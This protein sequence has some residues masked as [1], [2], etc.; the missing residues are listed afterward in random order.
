MIFNSNA[1]IEPPPSKVPL[2]TELQVLRLSDESQKMTME[3][4]RSIHGEDFKLDDPSK[5]KDRGTRMKK[6]Y[7]ED[8]GTLIVQSVSNFSRPAGSNSNSSGPEDRLRR[9]AL[10]K[11]ENYGFPE[12]HCIEAYDFCEGDTDAALLLLFRKYMRIPDNAEPNENYP[13]DMAE[14]ELLELRADEKSALES[15]YDTAFVEKEHNHIWNLKFKIDHLLKHSPSETR[16]QREAAETASK[17]KVSHSLANGKKEKSR[18]RN[19]DRD[20]TCKY[21]NNCRF[22]HVSPVKDGLEKKSR[23]KFGKEMAPA[24]KYYISCSLSDYTKFLKFGSL[25]VVYIEM[26]LWF[27]KNFTL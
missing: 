17:S 7:W 11:L 15:I 1:S 4:L 13:S 21:G 9:Y 3:T 8:R 18:C 16:K 20:G 19:F 25:G 22:A 2:K 12:S 27:I 23:G 5:Y 24:F 14:Q 10:V 26:P 6:S